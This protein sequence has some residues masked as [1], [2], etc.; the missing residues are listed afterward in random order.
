MAGSGR[1]PFLFRGGRAPAGDPDRRLSPVSSRAEVPVRNPTRS[2][3][4][5]LLAAT[6]FPVPAAPPAAKPEPKAPSFESRFEGMRFRNIGPFRGGRVT[7]VAGVR[8]QRNVAY[9]GATGG[10]VWKTTDGGT[11]WEAVSDKDFRTGSVGAV[12]VRRVGPERR[13]GRDGRGAD[14]RQRLA[15]RR[16]LALD[17]RGADAGS[18]SAW[19]PR[20]R[21][22]PCASTRRTPTS[23]WVAAQGKVWGPSEE[24][25]VYRTK[26]GGKTWTRVLFVDAA[27]GASDLVLD[28]S[29]PRILYAGDL[30]GRCG[31]RGSSSRAVP[32]AASGARTTAATPGRS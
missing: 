25:G 26:D 4:V 31:A 30:A 3:L 32:G 6:A 15:R 16:R 18:T 8:G 28:P 19:R 13:L 12:A 5:L 21:S 23:A 2:S 7:A 10:G 22:R 14:P 24:R 20:S 27:T 11:S 17:R 29:N 1:R 9:Q